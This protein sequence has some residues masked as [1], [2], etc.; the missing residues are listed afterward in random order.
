[1]IGVRRELVVADT[2]YISRRDRLVARSWP[3]ATV[4]RLAIAELA[5]CSVTVAELQYGRR[6][7]KWG[8]RRWLEAEQEI[9]GHPRLSIGKRTAATWARLKDAERR[10]G[11][12]FSENDLWIAATAQ[13]LGVPLVTCDRAFQ[14]ME[15]L[16]VEVVYLPSRAPVEVIGAG[17]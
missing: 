16:D 10:D 9:A 14:R 3:Q 11:R 7:A 5:L 13:T 1:M 2:T 4:R 17:R 6:A 15:H 12:S 8:R